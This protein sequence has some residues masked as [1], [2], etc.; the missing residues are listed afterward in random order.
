MPFGLQADPSP[1]ARVSPAGCS[2]CTWSEL[3]TWEGSRNSATLV[4]PVTCP[5]PPPSPA[6]P[7]SV[8]INEIY[9][10]GSP[11]SP[12]WVE[13]HNTGTPP[14]HASRDLSIGIPL[15]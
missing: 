12:E 6:D 4:V 8:V 10:R 15:V 1:L 11:S 13:L 14:T 9:P 5:A 2:E 7:T 3:T